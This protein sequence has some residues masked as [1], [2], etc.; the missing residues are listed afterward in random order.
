MTIVATARTGIVLSALIATAAPAGAQDAR[1]DLFAFSAGARLVSAPTDTGM[2]H[3]DSS[4]LNLIDDSPATDWTGEAGKAVFVLELAETTRLARIAFDTAGLNRDRKAPRSF[5]LE[6][7]ESSPRSGFHP[8]LSGALQMARTNQSFAFEPDDR[9]VARWVRLTLHD[10]YGDDYQGFTGFHGYGEQLTSDATLTGLTGNY[11][12][13]S[14]WGWIHLTQSGNRVSGCYEYQNGVFDG[15]VEGR[16]LRLAMR[17]D[18]SE[19]Q[20][21]IFQFSPDGQKL[22]GLVRGDGAAYRDTY[23]AYY[24]AER[25]GG[26]AG[27]C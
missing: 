22:V 11:D 2:S 13:A 20:H 23:A 5:T 15:V 27:G 17:Q 18:G 8:V 1:T 12:G 25:T 10:N 19:P 21:G 7:S 6:V 3:M 9:P 4:P 14:G 24:S 16:V 26:R